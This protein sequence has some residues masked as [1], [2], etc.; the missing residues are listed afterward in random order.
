MLTAIHLA[1]KYAVSPVAAEVH[2]DIASAYRTHATT[3]FRAYGSSPTLDAV[4]SQCLGL[5]VV[6]CFHL[7]WYSL[8]SRKGLQFDP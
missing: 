5:L 6:A 4:N 8:V 1:G 2:S 7:G 3:K